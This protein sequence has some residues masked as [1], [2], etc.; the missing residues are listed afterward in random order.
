MDHNQKAKTYLLIDSQGAGKTLA[1][2][3]LQL[4][5][6]VKHVI[7]DFEEQVWPDDIPDGSLVL[8][9]G[10]PSN[11]PT[12]VIVIS[13]ADALRIVIAKLEASSAKRSASGKHP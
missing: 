6:G 2:R 10:Q 8:T 3:L 13:L 12:H 4:H 1:A 11:V 9:N 5:L 7:D